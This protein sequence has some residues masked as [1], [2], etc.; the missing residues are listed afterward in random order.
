MWFACIPFVFHQN[1]QMNSWKRTF[2]HL[3]ASVMTDVQSNAPCEQSS[4]QSVEVCDCKTPKIQVNWNNEFSSIVTGALL[5]VSR[6]SWMLNKIAR[7]QNKIY[8]IHLSHS[9]V[10]FIFLLLLFRFT[11]FYSILNHLGAVGSILWIHENKR[12]KRK[13]LNAVM[14]NG[15]PF[16]CSASNFVSKNISRLGTFI[17]MQSFCVVVVVVCTDWVS[18]RKSV[19]ELNRWTLTI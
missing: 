18:R 12:R 5:C 2:G 7:S 1:G 4:A 8:W 16:S 9:I 13:S 19:S 15:A 17:L 6:C 10:F 3:Q 11:I 14:S